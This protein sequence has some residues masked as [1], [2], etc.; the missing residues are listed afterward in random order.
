MD[1]ST[2]EKL[3]Q[4]V[5]GGGCLFMS[6]PHLTTNESREF[7]VNNLEPL[8]LLKGGDFS[9][10]FGLRVTG[11][12]DPIHTIETVK[13]EGTLPIVTGEWA[14]TGGRYLPLAEPTD[15]LVDL[16]EVEFCGADG[17]AH[18][19]KSGKPVLARHRLEE[20]EAYLLLTHDF[21]GNSWL[22]GFMTDL[23]HGLAASVPSL[24]RLEDP[25]GDVYY[26]VREEPGTGLRR[27]HFLNTDW[28]KPGNE[29]RCVLRLADHEVP[30][31]VRE[32]RMSEVLWLGDFSAIIDEDYLYVEQV[33]QSS[34][35]F[36]LRVHG[37]DRPTLRF[38]F[39][40]GAGCDRVTMS[41]RPIAYDEND[42]WSSVRIEFGS[43]S[44]ATLEIRMR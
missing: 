41:G 32:G 4:Y 8:N 13:T 33:T 10:L 26:T 30:L 31:T 9:D 23:V 44:T 5:E 19:G 29:K 40:S 35:S 36:L 6:V 28:T 38:R 25:S 11:R 39:L 20:G 37:I 7:L 42:V 18:D 15:A 12:G 3:R 16:A 21:P 14:L 34:R 17:V 24:V 43:S 1:E 2:Y 22:V 27:M